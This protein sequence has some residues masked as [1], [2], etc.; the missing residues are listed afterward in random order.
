MFFFFLIWS[1][2]HVLVFS[3]VLV[4]FKM[5]QSFDICCFERVQKLIQRIYIYTVDLTL[6][7]I[8]ISTHIRQRNGAYNK[9]AQ[10]NICTHNNV[11]ITLM[12]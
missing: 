11:L 6:K 9:S 5:I 8:P 3:A 12:A 10:A 4:S 1:Q 2:K 7:Q